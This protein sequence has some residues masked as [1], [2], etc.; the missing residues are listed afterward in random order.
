MMVIDNISLRF[1]ELRDEEMTQENS[2]FE[3]ELHKG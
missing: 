1:G 2:S 3:A